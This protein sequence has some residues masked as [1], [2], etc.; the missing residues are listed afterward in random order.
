MPPLILSVIRCFNT[1]SPAGLS[2]VNFHFLRTS[3]KFSNL[4]TFSD[5]SPGYLIDTMANLDQLLMEKRLAIPNTMQ[6]IARTQFTDLEPQRLWA[7]RFIV[8]ALFAAYDI[9]M[10]LAWSSV[11]IDGDI[12]GGYYNVLTFAHSITN[13]G[14]SSTPLLV[15]CPDH[16]RG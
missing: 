16:L 14:P 2:R 3:A 12:E 9:I 6:R 4:F 1:S 5:P 13:I 8:C 7:C 11:D 15:F 10:T